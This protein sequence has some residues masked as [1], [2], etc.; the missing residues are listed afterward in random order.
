MKKREA[1]LSPECMAV[2]GE[3]SHKDWASKQWGSANMHR[4]FGYKQAS[5]LY[6]KKGRYLGRRYWPVPPTELI[7]GS[8]E[9]PLEPYVVSLSTDDLDFRFG[10]SRTNPFALEGLELD[11][12]YER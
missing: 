12:K 6:H 9:E 7:Q 4:R 8:P 11:G 2:V 5:G 3:L 10:N 1:A